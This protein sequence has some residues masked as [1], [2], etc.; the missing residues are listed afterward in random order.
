MREGPTCVDCLPCCSCCWLLSRFSRVQLFVTPWTIALY[1]PL[2]ME[3]P[4]QEYWSELLFPPP[5]D[6]PDPGIKP[7]SL[8]LA[9]GFFTTAPA[10][11]PIQLTRSTLLF[12]QVVSNSLRPH[13]LQHT[14]PPCP[15]PSP[16]ACPSSHPSNG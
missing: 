5:K 11:K 14:G 12:S 16:G 8:P 13:G 3:F 7:T 10:G 1:A 15:S 2:S 9:G 4:R 6:L